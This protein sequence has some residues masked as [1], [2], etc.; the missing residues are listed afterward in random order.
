MKFDGDG[1]ATP[2]GAHC[3]V[4]QNRD[5]FDEPPRKHVAVE[6]PNEHE[7]FRCPRLLAPA[8]FGSRSVWRR[9]RKGGSGGR[10]FGSSARGPSP[11]QTAVGGSECPMMSAPGL[12][13]IVGGIRE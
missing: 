13:Y 12:V 3:P 6:E 4:S 1:L 11:R 10:R 2:C 8:A 9:M 5:E 7:H